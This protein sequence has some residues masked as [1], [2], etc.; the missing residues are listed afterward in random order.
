MSDSIDLGDQTRTLDELCA[1]TQLPKRTIRYYIQIGLLERPIGETR[2]ARYG[3]HHLRRLLQ[4]HQLSQAGFSLARIRER[5]DAGEAGGDG[6][7]AGSVEQWTRL[8]LADG[9]ELSI[10]PDR[11]SLSPP[12]IRALFREALAVYQRVTQEGGVG[13][14][15]DAG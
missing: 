13:N 9:L 12:Q 4:I 1:L 11:A 7:R 8:I 5:L 10:N 6:P 3:E 15:S 2:A 14:G